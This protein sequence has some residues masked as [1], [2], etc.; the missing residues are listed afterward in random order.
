MSICPI[1]P[2]FTDKEFGKRVL[3]SHVTYHAGVWTVYDRS[4]L[5]DDDTLQAR[6]YRAWHPYGRLRTISGMRDEAQ[7]WGDLIS[8]YETL[9]SG[10]MKN[11]ASSLSGSPLPSVEV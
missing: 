2:P 7:T 1:G 6:L 9:T 3:I 10:A 11:F 4:L 5:F 8:S